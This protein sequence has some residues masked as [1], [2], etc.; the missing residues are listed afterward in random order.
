MRRS[1]G[2][3]LWCCIRGRHTTSS[4]QQGLRRI[5]QALDEVHAQTRDMG[6]SCLLETTAGQGSNL[7]YRF[8]QLAAI[9]EGVRDPD[10]LGVCVDTCHVFAAGY[11]LATRAEYRQ[12]MRQLDLI[13]GL[14]LVKAI[15]LN[16]SKTPAGARRDR[17]EHIGQGYLGTEPFRYLLNDRRFRKVPMYLETPKGKRG[18]RDWDQI[19]LQTLRG[20]IGTT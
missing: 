4:E 10:R 20:L 2:S 8:E 3:P 1:W 7:G 9:L 15:H 11:P 18:R 6:A 12:T 5:V 19:N 13:V 16:D 14:Q 17:H